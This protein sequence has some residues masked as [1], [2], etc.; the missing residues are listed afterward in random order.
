M[1]EQVYWYILKID[2][3]NCEIQ[4]LDPAQISVYPKYWGPF[5]SR[6]EAIAKRIGLIRA[7]KCQPQ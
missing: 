5:S 6:E 3:G 7:G 4:A 1:T 2:G